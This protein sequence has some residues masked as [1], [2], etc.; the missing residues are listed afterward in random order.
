MRLGLGATGGLAGPPLRAVASRQQQTR[1]GDEQPQLSSS[2]LPMHPFPV[3]PAASRRLVLARDRRVSRL[4]SSFFGHLFF[5]AGSSDA[6][7]MYAVQV[8]LANCV[9]GQFTRLVPT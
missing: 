2:V 6:Y 5:M 7:S 9:P 3:P 1:V 4:S 8:H